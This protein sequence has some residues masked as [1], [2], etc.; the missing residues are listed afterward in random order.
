MN[1][2]NLQSIIL[3]VRIKSSGEIND[4]ISTTEPLHQFEPAGYEVTSLEDPDVE[5]F[6]DGRP[7]RSVSCAGD[8]LFQ[9]VILEVYD[10]DGKRE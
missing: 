6:L 7:P 4:V 5:K 2:T 1:K 8:I 10:C 9:R 3:A